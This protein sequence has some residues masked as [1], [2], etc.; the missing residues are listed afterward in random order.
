MT[1]F[2]FTRLFRCSPSRSSIDGARCFAIWMGLFFVVVC[3]ARAQPTKKLIALGWYDP[4]TQQARTQTAQI[5]QTPFDGT[6]IS[7]EVSPPGGGGRAFASAFSALRWERAWFET[8]RQNLQ[9]AQWTRMRDNFVKLN[10]NPGSIDWFDDAAW[11]EI[12]DHFRIAAWLAREGGLKGIVFDAEPYVAPYAVF[13]YGRA[14]VVVPVKRTFAEYKAKARERGRQVMQAMAEEF[15]DIVILTLF[16][17]SSLLAERTSRGNTPLGPPVPDEVLAVHHYGLLVPF[18]DGWFDALPPRAVLHDGN[19]DAYWYWTEEQ[20]AEMKALLGRQGPALVSPENREKH[21]RQVRLASTVYLDAYRSQQSAN[22][23]HP[24]PQLSMLGA[25]VHWA[26]KHA[27]EYVWVY[28]EGGRWFP[29]PSGAL[30]VPTWEARLPGVTQTLIAARDGPPNPPP[31]RP[32]PAP[33]QYHRE[34]VEIAEALRLAGGGPNLAVNGTFDL[35]SS[36][37]EPPPRWTYWTDQTVPTGAGWADGRARIRDSTGGVLL[38]RIDAIPGRTYVVSARTRTEGVG[39]PLLEL[40][41]ANSGAWLGDRREENLY[42]QVF[43]PDATAGADGWRNLYGVTTLPPEANQLVVMLIAA[44]QRPAE[45]AIWFDDVVVQLV[46]ETATGGGASQPVMV[47]QPN[48]PA[49]GGA[50]VLNADVSGLGGRSYQWLHDGMPLPGARSPALRLPWLTTEQS[51]IYEV[52]V[53]T[54][55]GVTRSQPVTLRLPRTTR[56]VNLSVQHAADDGER[57]LIAGFVLEGREPRP[58]VVRGIG[59]GLAAFGVSAFL[60]EPRLALFSG[61]SLVM[62]RTGWGGDDGRGLGA[63]PLAPGSLDAVLAP[64]LMLGAYTVQVRKPPGLGVA[65]ALVEVYEAAGSKDGAQLANLSTRAFLEIGQTLMAG[66]VIAGTDSQKVMLRAVGPGLVPLGVTGALSNPRLELW[67]GNRVLATN[68]D[69]VGD[70]GSALGALPLVAG[71]RDAVLRAT[72]SAGA[73]TVYC[74]GTPGTRGVI[75]LEVFIAP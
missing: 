23:R 8:A 65:E 63:F 56:L 48:P 10:A 30:P 25:N 45:D 52:L 73:Y 26:L 50:A 64:T 42:N 69:W 27:D 7:V 14:H 33:M 24:Y 59:P 18:V 44:S 47:A 60:A 37:N 5:E 51:G 15:P 70:D 6:V 58:L 17:H 53:T 74:T 32:T 9:A 72:L 11:R 57:T 13:D 21:R 40:R 31:N 34:A 35:G 46:P 66:L 19:E 55:G 36:S 4:T 3:V 12:A 61:S 62:E 20:F 54:P 2:A 75:L 22:V 1:P 38:Q 67:Q 41:F 43:Y 68:D 39:V 29:A 16:M 28:N 71:S 49:A